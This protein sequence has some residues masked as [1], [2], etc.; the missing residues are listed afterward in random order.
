MLAERWQEIEKLYHSACEQKPDDR[1]AYLESATDDE[2]LRREVESLLANEAAAARFLET[3]DPERGGRPGERVPVGEQ[4][5]PYV[6]LEFLGAGGMGE[7]YKVRDTRL[8][9]DAAMKFVPHA[10]AT[11][12]AA[13]ERFQREARAASALNHPRICTIYDSGEHQGR[14]YFVMELLEGESLKDRMDGKCVPVAQLLDFAVQICDGL[15]A[16]HTKGIVHRDIK[17]ANIFVTTGGQI[18]IL[19]FGLAK[20]VTEPQSPRTV[21][22]SEVEETTSSTVLSRPGGVMG[23]LAY[24][25][26]EQARSGDV[27]ARTDIFSLGVV[28]Y[29]M[30]TGRQPFRGETPEARISST[31]HDTPEE[32]SALNRAVP[33]GLDRIVLKALEKKRDSRYQSAGELLAELGALQQTRQRRAKWMARLGVAFG[34]LSLIAAVAIIASNRLSRT[35]G[36][37]P[38]IGQRQM[39]ANPVNDSVFTVAISVDGRQIAYSDLRGVHIRQVDTGDVQDMPVPEQFCFR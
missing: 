10:F 21:A 2:E 27:D 17:P 8:D 1:L 12:P 31:L 33:K 11:D 28:L 18:K 19:D 13:L 35:D 5:G 3:D 39:T 37:A 38:N 9:R 14:P 6:V 30:A 34:G 15:Q 22:V 36:D 16:A 24:L 25:S 7:V 29:Q 32:P 4:I 23:T 20:R 26:P